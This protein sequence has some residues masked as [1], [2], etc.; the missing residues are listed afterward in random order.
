MELKKYIHRRFPK[1][2]ELIIKSFDNQD[3][4]KLKNKAYKVGTLL[5]S[6]GQNKAGDLVIY[7]RTKEYDE[8]YNGLYYESPT[9]T[10]GFEYYY[11]FPKESCMIYQSSYQLLVKPLVEV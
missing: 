1:N 5:K 2:S 9:W 10:G 3:L 8:Y 7:H 6:S 11:Y 4:V